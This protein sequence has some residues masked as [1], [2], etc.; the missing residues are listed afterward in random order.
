METAFLK[1]LNMSITA[2]WTAFAVMVVRLLLKKAPKWISVLLWGAVGI[3]LVFPFS[4][5][6][7]FSLIPSVETVP[8]DILYSNTPTIH[9]GVAVLNSAVNPIIS[10]SLAP[11]VG[12]SVNPVQIVL[13]IASIIWAAGM[14]AMLLY[15]A[16]SYL[17][18][19]SKVKEAIP[20]QERIWLCDYVDTPFILGIVRPRIYLPSAVDGQDMQYVIAHE[21]AH[22]KRGDHLWKPLGFLLLTVYWFQPVLW[23]AYILF[24]R[25]IELAC[26][27]KV[28]RDMGPDIKKPYS[29]AL[30]NCSVSWGR[31]A[32]CPLAFGETGVKGRVKS[33]LNY[34]KP[35]L[36]IMVAA[37]L[38]CALVVL[39][40]LTNPVLSVDEERLTLAEVVELSQKGEALTWEDFEN[41]PSTD[42]GSGLYIRRYEIDDMFSLLIG[43]S[44]PGEK[45]W[46]FYLQAN[47]GSGSYV[48]IREGDVE[49]FI[50][51]H[52]NNVVGE[53]AGSGYPDGEGKLVRSYVL[54]ES[55]DMMKPSVSLY[56]DGTF[57]F[58]FSVYSSYIGFGQYELKENRLTLRTDDWN[59]VYCFD[60]VGDTI[61]FN[62]EASSEMFWSSEIYDGAVFFLD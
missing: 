15:A 28:I 29:E 47:D 57:T 40:F 25:D 22:L 41:Y 60:I 53:S 49:S 26:D 50:N 35:A 4:M 48:D 27:E 24:C 10:E 9:S 37:A 44:H 30:I 7:I 33:V 43:G 38:S 1:I 13:F 18:V 54:Q 11:N 61:I 16:A 32:A 31:V 39:C 51:Q 20:V 58:T 56:D 17:K 6:S 19:H 62:G 8:T 52:K 3:R 5:E 12:D 45:A 46:Y 21:K 42:V 2:G 34:R 36:W 59:L 55:K 14:I 23:I